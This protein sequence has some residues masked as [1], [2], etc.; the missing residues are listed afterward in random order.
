MIVCVGFFTAVPCVLVHTAVDGDTECVCV[1]MW[2]CFF[3]RK[4]NEFSSLTDW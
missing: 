3:E 1:Y 4:K 2:E